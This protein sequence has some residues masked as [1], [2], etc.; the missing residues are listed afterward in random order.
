LPVPG[1][2][3]CPRSSRVWGRHTMQD[4]Q[5]ADSTHGHSEARSSRSTADYLVSSTLRQWRGAVWLLLRLASKNVGDGGGPYRG[6]S[7][8]VFIDRE[9]TAAKRHTA[10]TARRRG[11]NDWTNVMFPLTGLC[12]DFSPSVNQPPAEGN[13]SKSSPI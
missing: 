4:D 2:C 12:G 13:V 1:R 7:G 5:T 3:T 11:A 10:S 8:A 6:L 9:A